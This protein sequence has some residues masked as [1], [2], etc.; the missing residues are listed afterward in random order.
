MTAETA[1]A[2]QV[3]HAAAYQGLQLWRN[4]VGVFTD[5]R[6]I[7]VRYGLANDS[8]QMNRVIKSSDLIGI[9][10]VLITPQHVGLVVGVFTALETKKSA[11]HFSEKDERAVAQRKFHEIVRQV[12]GYAGF[13]QSPADMMRIIGRGF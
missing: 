1:I 8:A 11:W 6:G 12:G 13:C 5:E 3:S 2:S 10:P 9:T 7:P 4:N